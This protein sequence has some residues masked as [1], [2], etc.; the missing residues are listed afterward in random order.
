MNATDPEILMENYS[1]GEIIKSQKN[2]IWVTPNE[3]TSSVIE[4][5]K[6]HNKDCATII[7]KGEPRGIFTIKD[8]LTIYKTHTGSNT[9]IL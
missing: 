9:L 1:I 7:D 5:M 3:K 8:V 4:Q 2:D 6:Q